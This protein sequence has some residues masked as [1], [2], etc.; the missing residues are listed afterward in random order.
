MLKQPFTCIVE[1][2]KCYYLLLLQNTSIYWACRYRT[3]S[4][5]KTLFEHKDAVVVWTNEVE[6]S[7]TCDPNICI[8]ELITFV[9][10][11]CLKL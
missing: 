9:E 2:N 5:V 3:E 4:V 1:I 8:N 11:S 10:Y 6:V 7:F